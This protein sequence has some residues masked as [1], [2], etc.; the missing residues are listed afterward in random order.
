MTVHE[1]SNQHLIEFD[2]KNH[3]FH[4]HNHHISY[5]FSIETGGFLSHLYFGKRI[6]TYHGQL[7]NP[8]RDRGFSGNLPGS[9]DR[10]YSLD[11]LLQEYSSKGDGDYRV[12]ATVIRQPD[13]SRSAFF[14]YQSHVIQPGKP[15]LKGLPAAYT[16]N[17]EEA[18]T[19]VVTL[20]DQLSD[21]ELDLVYTIYQDRDVVTRSAN[22]HNRGKQSVHLEKIASMQVD[23]PSGN[24]DVISLPG[25]H[26]NERHIQREPIG[27]GVKSFESRR[28]TT[29]HQ[30]N[31]FIAVCDPDTDEFQGDVYGFCLVYSG[32][33]KEEVEKD[34]YGQI[35]IVIGINDDQFDWQI[36][37]GADFQTPEV[38]MA[39]SA[40][41]LNDMSHTYHHLL[42]ERVARGKYQYAQRP[43]VVN[44]WE[45][46]F[47]DFTEAKLREIVDA[48]KKT[49]IE[50]FVLDD[51]WFGHRDDDHSSLGDW[52]VFAKKFPNG[53]KPFSDYIHQQGM[54]F[55]IWFEPEM[56]S[57]DSDLYRAHPDYLLKVPGR[58]PSPARS[59]YV[60]DMG[61]AEVRENVHEQ[62][63]A[64]FNSCQIDYVKW[65]MNRHLSDIYS[66][67]LP[68]EKQGEVLHRYVLGLY[69]L[70]EELTEENPDI[71]WEG[72]SGGGGRF[73]AG[74][75]YY[76]PQSWTSDNTDAIARLKIQYGT[77][78]AY[79]I[80][81]M[82]A[83]VSV[84]PNQQTGRATPLE[85]RANVAMSGVLGY[86]LDLT[87]MS[88][89]DRAHVSREV[90]FYKQIRPV[91]QYGEFSRLIDPNHGNRCAWQFVAPD[92]SEVVAFSFNLLA[93][94][95]PEFQQLKLMGLDA[96]KLYQNVETGEMI[97]GDELMHTG[98]YEPI[99]QFDF[100]SNMYHFKAVVSENGN[101]L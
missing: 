22:L 66:V 70:L 55:G 56:I 68:P 90:A 80:S 27:Y 61:R 16:K 97:G 65:D 39:Y 42:R 74:L 33:H 38:I 57:F 92:Q 35:R 72:C 21:L 29:S 73:D 67:G 15:V 76:M 95:Q 62:M 11:F 69:Q 1:P 52:K 5:L 20:A 45:A 17:D 91:I 89:K 34:Q 10:T 48:A 60:L 93:A 71:L 37:P 44:N 25:A 14:T 100:S 8:K 47:M 94:A 7:K 13:G 9:Q 54:K 63:K 26:V 2:D 49:G 30:M 3:V 98:F 82:T 83:H 53:L 19:L 101:S 28:G 50:M 40:N 6:K 85:T 77:S 81:S 36:D 31:N 96:G 23:L 75:L 18:E 51:G 12:P 4:L 84:S 59:Q 99:H 32:N 86:E 43:I 46:T 24:K 78:L 41:G 88:A 64:I 87:K 58:Q 79:P